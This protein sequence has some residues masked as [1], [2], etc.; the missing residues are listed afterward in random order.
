MS[1]LKYLLLAIGLFSL[2]YVIINGDGGVGLMLTWGY[3][4]LGIATL[5]SVV[6]PIFHLAQNPKGAV[7]NLLGLG[8][9][10]VVLGV[11]YALSSAEP[12]RLPS[13]E[14]YD[15]AGGLLLTDTG[16]YTAYL[17]LVGAILVAIFGEIRNSFK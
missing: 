2:I 16:L 10:V 15:N 3:V 17:A 6:F 11:S 1:L 9:V 13:N 12:I 5:V 4:L 14:I 7:R 8:L